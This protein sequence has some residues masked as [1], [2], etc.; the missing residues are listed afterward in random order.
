MDKSAI[1][2]HAWTEDHPIRLDDTRILQLATL[3]LDS[4][5]EVIPIV[6]SRVKEDHHLLFKLFLCWFVYCVSYY[7]GLGACAA[8]WTNHII[9]VARQH[10]PHHPCPFGLGLLP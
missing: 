2:E 1:A 4:L 3:S 8:L 10:K 5:L 7:G 9:T 6:Q